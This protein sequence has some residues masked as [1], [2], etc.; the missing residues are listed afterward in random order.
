MSLRKRAFSGI[1]WSFGQQFSVQVLSFGVSI[2]LARLLEPADFGILGMIAILIAV[3]NALMDGGLTSS[4]IR[5][6][7]LTSADYSTVFYVNIGGSILVYIGCYI[8]APLVA[9]FFKQEILTAV[10]RLYSLT[11]V[12]NA[13]AGVQFTRLTKDMNFKKQLIIQLPSVVGGGLVGIFLSY[14]GYGVWSLVWMHITQSFLQT[15]QLWFSSNWRPEAIFDI[16]KFK[17]HVKFGYKLMLSGILDT[18]FNNIYN[19]VIGK[20]FSIA[21]VGYYTRAYSVRQ[22]PVQ[23]IAGALNRVTYPLFAS[24][25]HDDEKLRSAYKKLMQQVLFWVAPILITLL[26][27]A[28]PFFTFLFTDKWLPAVPYFQLLCIGGI[29]YPLH[30]YNLNILNVKG[31]SDLFLKLEIIKKSIVLAGVLSTIRFG[32]YGL[33]YF[34]IFSSVLFYFINGWYSGKMIGY[35]VMNQLA[36]ILPIF[37]VAAAV[38]IIV[39]FLNSYVIRTHIPNNFVRM[40]ICS[41]TYFSLYFGTAYIF[42]LPAIG[43]LGK[44]IS[45]YK[46]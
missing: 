15:V 18:F 46:K 11:F 10:I 8:M 7:N 2:I 31:R 27:I 25:Q 42:K 37:L 32:I 19:V 43:E 39:W 13:F 24:I 16:Q 1:L 5:S 20:F 34:E 6:Q 14:S 12:I 30:A 33:L 40:V 44:L 26:I 41:G 23:N 4:L 28:E 35:S 9:S 22:L 36:D 38:G 29:M 21:Q 3:G 45:G 17:M